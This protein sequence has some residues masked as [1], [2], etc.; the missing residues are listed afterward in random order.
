MALSRKMLKGMNLTEEQ[1]DT[2]IEAHTE[3]VGALKDERDMFKEKAE[4]FDA[5]K[6]K[7]EELQKRIDE[8][9]KASSNSNSYKEQYEAV[10][11]EFDD[12]KKVVDE[13]TSKRNKTEA[14]KSMLKEIG[15]SDKRLDSVLKVSDISAIKLD[16][17][18]KIEESD[19]LKESLKT[20]WSDFIVTEG[21]K[22]A[23]TETPPAGNGNTDTGDHYASDRVAKQRAALYG[24]VKSKED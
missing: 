24:S 1:V 10:K 20:E 21:K 7:S 23:D 9:E 22:G 13:E 18:G 5:E 17:D 15:I 3:T 16:K 12:F 14:L 4:S 11:K 8:L 6:K 2:I 19:K